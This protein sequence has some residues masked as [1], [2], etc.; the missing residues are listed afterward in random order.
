MIKNE[1]EIIGIITKGIQLRMEGR[2]TLEIE[3]EQHVFGNKSKEGKEKK[4]VSD[5]NLESKRRRIEG[6]CS[7]RL[8]CPGRGKVI[9]RK[10]H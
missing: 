5:K 1:K 8:S 9:I 10:G 4:F 3:E 7:G 6:V 2:I